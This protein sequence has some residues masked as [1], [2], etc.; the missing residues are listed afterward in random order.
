MAMISCSNAPRDSDL[1]PKTRLLTA[2]LAHLNSSSVRSAQAFA[3]MPW[4]CATPDLSSSM[5]RRRG[6]AC[7]PS[8]SS[9]VKKSGKPGKASGKTATQGAHAEPIARCSSSSSAKD[10]CVGARTSGTPAPSLLH[11]C[12]AAPCS[13]AISAVRTS[14]AGRTASGSPFA[15][16]SLQTMPRNLVFLSTPRVR[17]ACST[18]RCSRNHW[19]KGSKGTSLPLEITYARAMR[20]H[21]RML[22]KD[23]SCP[24]EP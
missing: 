3:T 16:G 15:M 18:A 14:E 22:G 9:S 12:H 7:R 11:C 2:V 23:R 17:P 10:V 13:R 1:R 21:A 19:R 6:L 5:T 4:S 8:S 20:R 24:L